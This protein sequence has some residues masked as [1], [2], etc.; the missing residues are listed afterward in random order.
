MKNQAHFD[1]AGFGRFSY[2]NLETQN[3]RKVKINVNSE[4]R[5]GSTTL[6]RRRQD[7]ERDILQKPSKQQLCQKCSFYILYSSWLYSRSWGNVILV[8]CLF[9][10]VA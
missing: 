10:F 9:K 2:F 7:E 6:Y 4:R 3:P 1:Q 5:P 8:S